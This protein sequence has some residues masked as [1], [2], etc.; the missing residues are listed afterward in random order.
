VRFSSCL[1]VLGV[2]AF[3][4]FIPSF[5]NAQGLPSADIRSAAQQNQR[6]QQEQQLRD[7]KQFE[8]DLKSDKPSV[9]LDV[10][11]TQPRSGQQL[12][13]CRDI[14]KIELRGVTQYTFDEIQPVLLNYLDRCLTA[15]DIQLLMTEVTALYFL[16]G[17]ITSRVYLAEQDLSG[18]VLILLLVEGILDE[19]K[20]ED[21]EDG[22]SVSPFNVYPGEKGEPL[23]L[24]DIEQAVDQI[25]RL[26][27][28]NV[29]MHIEPGSNV[30]S[31]VL[32]F[33][34]ITSKLWQIHVSHDNHGS[35]STGQDQG[36]VTATIDNLLGLNDYLSLTYRKTLPYHDG[37]Q[38]SESQSLSYIVPFGYT[39][40]ALNAN[41]SEYA[42]QLRV[43]SG[44]TLLSEGNSENYSLRVDRIMYRGQDSRWNLAAMISSKK[45]ESFL[46]GE[47]LAVSSRRLSVFDIE[48]LYTF[49][50]LGGGGSVTLGYSQ[51]V[52][53]FGSLDDVTGL[54]RL[55]PHAQF[56]KW[57]L[58]VNYQRPFQF[59][60]RYF[61][62]SS[63]F[64]GQ[65]AEDVL[66][67]SEAILIG[68]I[69]SV[70]GFS[71]NSLS[72]DHG[73]YW[74]NDLS[75]P[76]QFSTRYDS[77][78]S[79]RPYLGLDYGSVSS[80]NSNVPHGD[81]AGLTLGVGMFF[82][83]LYVDVFGS[84]ALHKSDSMRNEGDLIYFRMSMTF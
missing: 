58:G 51:G 81:L 77:S 23:N 4:V 75:M 63:S 35:E 39:T 36:G 27:S 30:G 26:Q 82:G 20:I 74:R 50:L 71:R 3:L 67:G 24:R 6:I 66:Y 5:A 61:T 46:E 34:N 83:P 29:V 40:V 41:R 84:H 16:D 7:I 73:Y 42:T 72:G 33:E 38:G 68:G 18:G 78:I 22:A 32:V 25:N 52:N 49:P 45:S 62:Y 53:W 28:N 55:A 9:K 10:P 2:I 48:S 70:R 80:F 17:Y 15:N 44:N 60:N 12:G 8:E 1:H 56:G 79:V 65:Y 14:S 69:Y 64:S 47:L 37:V 11:L 59:F 57:T 19:I 31:S 43:P 21:G 76:M 54:P 13:V